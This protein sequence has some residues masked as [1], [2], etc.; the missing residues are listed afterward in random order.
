MAGT[1][2]MVCELLNTCVMIEGPN[3]PVCRD[4]QAGYPRHGLLAADAG[5]NGV[6]GS[7]P[8]DV[9]EKNTGSGASGT[10]LKSVLLL[11]N[12]FECVRV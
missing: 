5:Q 8:V 2:T 9:P 4:K 12:L 10:G 3:L 6:T 1:S 7:S 11:V